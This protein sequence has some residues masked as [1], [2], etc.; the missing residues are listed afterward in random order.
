MARCLPC[1]RYGSDALVVGVTVTVQREQLYTFEVGRVRQS[2]KRA[3]ILVLV[4]MSL[5]VAIPAFLLPAPELWPLAGLSMAGIIYLE[6]SL[7]LYMLCVVIGIDAAP[8]DPL[9]SPFGRL[10]ASLAIVDVT[11]VEA[12]ALWTML[13][14]I[15]KGG[16]EG[17]LTFPPSFL[18]RGTGVFLFALLL[19]VL[20]GMN[21]GGDL[22]IALWEVRALVLAVPVMVATTILVRDHTELRRFGTVLAALLLL[23]TLETFWRYMIYVRSGAYKGA[24]EFAFA[25]E[26][27]VFV[28]L[29]M[30]GSAAWALWGPNRKERLL[31]AFVGIVAVVVLITMRRRAGLIAGEAGLLAIGLFLLLKDRRRFMLVAPVVLVLSTVYLG[32]FWDNPNSLGQPARAFRTVFDSGASD[33]RDQSSDAYRE[34]EKRNL[35]YNIRQEPLE[36]IGF[37]VPY[38][39]PYQFPDLSAFWPFWAYIPHNTVLWLWMRAGILGFLS[40]WFLLGMAMSRMVQVCKASD[41]RLIIAAAGCVVA[42]L[43][44]VVLFSFVDL[45]LTNPRLMIGFGIAL[46]LIG[47]LQRLGGSGRSKEAQPGGS[48]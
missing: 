29:L 13:C 25:H 4:F 31:A 15:V 37:G 18:M 44:M 28:G 35:W 32:A 43:T 14:A 8:L 42:F 3:G 2:D 23:M 46:G 6:P 36:G 22:T 24:L 26:T 34:A 9:T 10:F 27:S 16:L 5:A 38:A 7:G 17:S 48:K 20:Q 1:R 21:R 11:P 40:F 12:L 19:G 30:V 39:K 47:T 45:G 33:S 41:D